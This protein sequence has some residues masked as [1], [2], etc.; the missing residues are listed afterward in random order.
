MKYVR[1]FKQQIYRNS[2]IEI[3]AKEIFY[4][5]LIKNNVS[6]AFIYSGGSIMP[7]IDSLYNK[8]INL[9]YINS[10]EQNCGHALTGFSK[11]N[12]DHNNK[13]IDDKWSG[14]YKSDNTYA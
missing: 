4:N 6:D 7:L 3:T 2:G 9:Y 11:S 5:T 12:I 1:T 14:I 10:H 8:D 13:A